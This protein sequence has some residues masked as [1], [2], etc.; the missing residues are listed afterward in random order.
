MKSSDKNVCASQEQVSE[1]DSFH[2]IFRKT[3]P[4]VKKENEIMK[5]AI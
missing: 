2:A 4:R 5:A 3:I 1:N